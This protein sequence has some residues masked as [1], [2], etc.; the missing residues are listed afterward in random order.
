MR[1]KWYDWTYNCETLKFYDNY[2]LITYVLGT[3]GEN[4]KK[5]WVVQL[6]VSRENCCE[7]DSIFYSL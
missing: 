1:S 5:K 3:K 6:K 7:M 4:F 2:M